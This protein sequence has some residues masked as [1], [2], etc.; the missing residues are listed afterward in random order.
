[1]SPTT[2]FFQYDGVDFNAV[3]GVTLVKTEYNYGAPLRRRGVAVPMRPGLISGESQVGPLILRLNCVVEAAS[4]N[5]LDLVLR[6][7]GNDLGLDRIPGGEDKVLKLDWKV[8]M[9]GQLN[10]RLNGQMRKR[11][12]G[13]LA[14]GLEIEFIAMDPHWYGPS[15]TIDPFTHT[16]DPLTHTASMTK[17]C[18]WL[19]PFIE[20]YPQATGTI[21]A[22]IIFENED[23][24]EAIQNTADF[25]TNTVD[26]DG[27]RIKGVT[28]EWQTTSNGGTNWSTGMAKVSGTFPR[29]SADSRA[30]KCTI[31]HSNPTGTVVTFKYTQRR[32]IR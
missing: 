6:D 15:V 16:S 23:T 8:T 28:R 19:Y 1:M 25:V 12:I 29:I 18:D 30:V 2:Y 3:H 31:G 14:A 10:C 7:I 24:G 22:T 20:V 17:D 9:N 21:T 11:Y 27:F 32:I 5:A 4:I 13:S 26:Q